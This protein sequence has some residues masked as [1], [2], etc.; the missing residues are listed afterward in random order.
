VDL[1]AVLYNLKNVQK[2]ANKRRFVVVLPR[3]VW[4]AI[5]ELK[6]TKADG[7]EEARVASEWLK[8]CAADG[9]RGVRCLRDHEKMPIDCDYP[10]N[11]DLETTEFFIMMETCKYLLTHNGDQKPSSRTFFG[12][13]R[14]KFRVICLSGYRGMLSPNS[15]KE[16]NPIAI[17][18][19]VGTFVDV[20]TSYPPNHGRRKW[21]NGKSNG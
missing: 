19:L 17:A 8:S 5:D 10:K 15:G 2:L 20:V 11:A 4:K 16:F 3:P 21:K 7:A 14:D 1:P 12:D 18:R 9:H 6:T 13:M